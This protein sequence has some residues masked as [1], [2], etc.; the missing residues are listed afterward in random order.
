MLKH[1]NFTYAS[2]SFFLFDFCLLEKPTDCSIFLVKS[3]EI[4]SKSVFV[5][6]ENLAEAQ[7]PGKVI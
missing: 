4:T 7:I 5:R 6:L 1:M 2:A 3:S